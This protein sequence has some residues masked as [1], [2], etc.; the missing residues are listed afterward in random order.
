MLDEAGESIGRRDVE[1]GGGRGRGRHE[2]RGKEGEQRR[3]DDG[4][5]AGRGDDEGGER[6]AG[7]GLT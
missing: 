5:D 3:G 4:G 6:V 2:V 1:H 7:A